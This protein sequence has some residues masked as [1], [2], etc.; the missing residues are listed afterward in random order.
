MHAEHF[1]AAT[2]RSF[3]I[4]FGEAQADTLFLAK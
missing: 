1:D 3:S 2:S 4:P